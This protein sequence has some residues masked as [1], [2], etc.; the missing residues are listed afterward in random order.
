MSRG[1]MFILSSI[2][3]SMTRLCKLICTKTIIDWHRIWS[4]RPVYIMCLRLQLSFSTSIVIVGPSFSFSHYLSLWCSL[5]VIARRIVGFS[6]FKLLAPPYVRAYLQAS[7]P[8]AF[9]EQVLSVYL[10]SPGH[11]SVERYHWRPSLENLFYALSQEVGVIYF[12][13]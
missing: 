5:D 9:L 13:V 6:A 11:D 1:I 3:S 8:G 12:D 2:A 4:T 10:Y 7:S